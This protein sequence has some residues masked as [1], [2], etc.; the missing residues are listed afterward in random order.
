MNV[1]NSVNYIWLPSGFSVWLP[2]DKTSG[3]G[4]A[5]LRV[6]T[7][8]LQMCTVRQSQTLTL[9]SSPPIHWLNLNVYGFV[10]IQM[11]IFLL[12]GEVEAE[13]NF[14]TNALGHLFFWPRSDVV[15]RTAGI[16]QIWDLSVLKITSSPVI[17]WSNRIYNIMYSSSDLQRLLWRDYRR[18]CK[19]ILLEEHNAI[20]FPAQ[21]PKNN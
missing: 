13:R 12:L 4:R 15:L 6:H 7:W 2:I 19:Y 21:S 16:C 17:L 11:K 1:V 20:C 9:E 10:L 14:G 3:N 5:G 8:F 18:L